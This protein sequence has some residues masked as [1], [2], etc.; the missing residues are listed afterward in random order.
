MMSLN[1]VKIIV[2]FAIAGAFLLGGFMFIGTLLLGHMRPMWM[3]FHYAP[4]Y[5]LYGLVGGGVLGWLI[6]AFGFQPSMPGRGRR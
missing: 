6:G 3:E 2:Y 1:K 5:A 4:H